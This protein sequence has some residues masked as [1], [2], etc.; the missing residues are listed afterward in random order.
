MADRAMPVTASAE[1]APAGTGTPRVRMTGIVKSYGAVR[2]VRGMD[3]E[4]APGEILGLIGANG[5]GK[6][7]LMK[8][9]AG[10]VEPDDGTIEI[11]GEQVSF[12]RPADAAKYGIVLVPQELQL[13]GDQSVAYNIF[14]ANLPSHWSVVSQRRLN[15]KARLLLGRVGLGEMNPRRLVGS[16]TS[17]EQRLV[18]L[19]Q[20]LAHEPE[21]IVLDEPSASLPTEIVDLLEP[22][23]RQLADDGTSI[24]YV[25]HRLGEIMRFTSRV[26]AMR[27]G[28]LAGMLSGAERS[29]P[30][31]VQLVGGRALAEEP[32][33]PAAAAERGEPVLRVRGLSG[34]RVR[35]VDLDLHAG[36][37]LGVGGLYGSGRSE[38][39]RLIAS[40][41][42]STAGSIE[43]FGKDLPRS[44]VV[45]LRSGVAYLPEERRRMIFGSM[46]TMS[47][48]TMSV[49]PR[50][51]KGGL[52]LSRDPEQKAFAK[53]VERTRLQG[54]A[55]AP[56]GT[57][58]GGNQQKAFLA[59]ALLCG[60]KLLLLDEP[61]VGVDVHARA[62]IHRFVLDLAAEGMTVVV[63]SADPEELVLL[64]SRVVMLIEGELT[65]QL[66]APFTVGDIVDASYD[67]RMDDELT[68]STDAVV[69]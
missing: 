13:V 12:K 32:P 45:A 8:S 69:S 66:H 10:D 52:L 44:P 50:L 15:V 20:G 56:I 37:V 30:A 6:S 25:S 61:T 47:N 40:M 41:Q 19:A 43:A 34:R 9:L 16:L 63:A 38:M 51:F 58:S 62:E 42:K 23:L 35:N 7:T 4:I 28:G 17:V 36:E 54:S 11:S 2:A 53:V 5:A 24:V 48:V 39:L 57:L 59:R 22:V 3:F 64:C 65:S 18:S 33:R 31:M 29:I 1:P 46:D 27:D 60:P 21:V 67:Q 55:R 68:K 26:V 49:L 14:L